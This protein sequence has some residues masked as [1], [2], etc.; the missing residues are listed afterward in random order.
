[1][2]SK[3]VVIGGPTA[4]GKT[5]LAA[6]VAKEFDGELISADSRQVYT[7]MDVGTGKDRPANVKIWGYD[8]V[9]PDE[10]F[11]MAD[12]VNFA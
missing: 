2:K 11:S 3:L 9:K 6:L 5:G 4:M 12:W 10:D 8:L 1:M 7:G